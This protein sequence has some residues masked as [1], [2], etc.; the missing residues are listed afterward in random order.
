MLGQSVFGKNAVTQ[1]VIAPGLIGTG[2]GGAYGVYD[3]FSNPYARDP[4]TSYLLKGAVGGVAAGG[5]GASINRN[6][7]D[8]RIYSATKSTSKYGV[9]G[10]FSEAL[11]R[12]DL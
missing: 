2:V 4:L 12:A 6:M 5:V 7:R 3:K 8:Y 1:Y 9:A 11:A 10:S